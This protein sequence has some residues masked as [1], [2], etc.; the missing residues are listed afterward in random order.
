MARKRE[1]WI[2]AIY[3]I[4]AALLALTVG[5]LIVVLVRPERALDTDGLFQ[6]V[7]A[8]AGILSAMVTAYLQSRD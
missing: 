5:P 2:V 7:I 4:G 8:L 6:T 1:A 3:F